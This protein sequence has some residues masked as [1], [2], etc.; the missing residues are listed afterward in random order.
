MSRENPIIYEKADSMAAVRF[1]VLY[2][3]K[4]QVL[5]SLSFRVPAFTAR[6]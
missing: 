5:L 1:G 4:Y 3:K 6:Q 2:N